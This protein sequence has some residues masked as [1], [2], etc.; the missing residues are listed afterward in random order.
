[1][2][3]YLKSILILFYFLSSNFLWSQNTDSL[4]IDDNFI[5]NKSE[6]NYLN[7]YFKA[8]RDTFDFT[9]KKVAFLEGAAGEIISTKSNFFK[10][11]IKEPIVKNNKVMIDFCVL[12]KE[13][14]MSSGGYDVFLMQPAKIF[15]NKQRKKIMAL[16]KS[17]Q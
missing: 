5:L 14:R 15:T 9:N 2:N 7:S 11:F 6:S 13:D 12:R 4:G 8:W 3:H 16:L 10:R 17:K 1:M